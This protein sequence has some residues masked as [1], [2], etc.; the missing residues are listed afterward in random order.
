MLLNKHNFLESILNNGATTDSTFLLAVSGGID[1]MCMLHLFHQLNL[2]IETAHV[3]YKLRGDESDADEALVR[4]TARQ[5]AI[6][7][8]A[9]SPELDWNH[10]SGIQE[11]ARIF[12]YE[13]FE[14]LRVQRQLDVIATAHHANDQA[15]TIL[16]N[17]SR[18]SGIR[19]LRGIN[20]R[21]NNLIRPL[22]RFTRD[23]I[24]A[25]VETEHILFRNDHTNET[26]DYSRNFI[27]NTIVPSFLTLN[28]Q[29]IQHLSKTS[30]L[31]NFYDYVLNKEIAVFI[32][33]TQIKHSDECVEF[34]LDEF[35]NHPFLVN[36]LYECL[37]P[38]GTTNN[39][40][41]NIIAALHQSE[42]KTFITPHYTITAKNKSAWV[43]PN[44]SS[45]Q[46]HSYSIVNFPTVIETPTLEMNMYLV[47]ASAVS[48]Y[49][50]ANTLFINYDII[51]NR[52]LT[53]RNW[54][55]SDVFK[56]FG[57]NGSK[58][59]SDYLSD[60]KVSPVEKLHT[61]VLACESEILAVMPHT[62]H[63]KYRALNTCEQL[64]VIE[65]KTKR[66]N[67]L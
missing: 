55:P 14:Q 48:D 25:Y 5:L 44:K 40:V 62:I 41:Q 29:F 51:S 18:G 67:P 31:A 17:L 43:T 12:R 2:K 36:Y 35:I 45:N 53:I 4:E 15:E 34:N 50:V 49:R 9:I 30:T 21:T 61:L 8:H 58:K 24:A 20:A 16:F 66:G 33:K 42:S 60:K 56:P 52:P 11:A 39:Q 1:S 59:V 10:S 37:T 46:T 27:R 26:N 32:R 28:P 64:L 3:N 22:L 23:D 19:G 13:W 57:L 65:C 47:P 38:Y 7:F 6:P 54:N 63:H